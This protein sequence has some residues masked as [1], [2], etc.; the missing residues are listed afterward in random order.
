MRTYDVFWMSNQDWY[1]TK[2]GVRI[3]KDDAPLAAHKS[4]NHYLEQ[5]G[6]S[7]EQWLEA[8]NTSI[9]IES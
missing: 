7:E 2:N 1:E 6:F 5:K 4:F 9:E 3:I 8:I